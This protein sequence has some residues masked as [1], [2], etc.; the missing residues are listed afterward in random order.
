MGVQER[1]AHFIL[2]YL[3]LRLTIIYH[4]DKEIKS[5]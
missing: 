4:N 5:S 2:V 3:L 1:E